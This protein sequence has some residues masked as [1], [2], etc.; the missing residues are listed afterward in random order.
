MTIQE[1]IN[2]LSKYPDN[3]ELEDIKTSLVVE[4][5]LGMNRIHSAYLANHRFVGNHPWGK[6]HHLERQTDLN[7]VAKAML[8]GLKL[9]NI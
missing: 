4:K 7:E 8:N 5:D 3:L 6:L 9:R 2:E 1:Y